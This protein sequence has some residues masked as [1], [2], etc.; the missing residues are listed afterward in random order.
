M[1]LHKSQVALAPLALELGYHVEPSTTSPEALLMAEDDVAF[2]DEYHEGE[3]GLNRLSEHLGDSTGNACG[4]G[5]ES[6]VGGTFRALKALLN[7]ADYL[8]TNLSERASKAS[9]KG[10]EYHVGQVLRHKRFGFRAVVFGWEERPHL[11]VAHWDGKY[12]GALLH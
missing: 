4:R 11:D 6:L 9:R 5:E 10:I 12:Q 2:E 1:L 3:L 7:V 8:D